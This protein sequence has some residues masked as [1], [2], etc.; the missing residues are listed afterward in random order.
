MHSK[1]ETQITVRPNEI[2]Y[3]RHVHQSVYLDYLLHAR[4]DQMKRC[5]K[6]SIEEFFKR[7]YSWAT[8]SISI[9][10]IKP[11]FLAETIIV[12][13]WV[14][15]LSKRSVQVSFLMLK[16]GTQEKA[17]QGSAVFV[18]INAETGRPEIIPEDIKEKY[19]I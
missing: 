6:M 18:M 15:E 3:N 8:K 14:K 19:S 5:Y 13:T 17:A 12:R 10:F 16:K 2:D 7:G 4:V 9:E 11:L 1:F